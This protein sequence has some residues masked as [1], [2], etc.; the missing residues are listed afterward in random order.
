MEKK[1][2]YIKWWLQRFGDRDDDTFFKEIVVG[3]LNWRLSLQYE[4]TDI[5][6]RID[7][8]NWCSKGFKHV[9]DNSLEDRTKDEL[10]A[11]IL[12]LKQVAGIPLNVFVN[13]K[14]CEQLYDKEI[15]GEKYERN[16]TMY[17]FNY[18]S[19]ECYGEWLEN[20][21]NQL[22]ETSKQL[23]KWESNGCDCGQPSCDICHG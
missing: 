22:K 4:Y 12:E 15:I 16:S 21:K 5:G 18:C 3:E 6:S 10:D 19:E 8:W 7:A 2:N 17:M 1:I 23:N 20:F 13:C 9:G 11:I 14:I